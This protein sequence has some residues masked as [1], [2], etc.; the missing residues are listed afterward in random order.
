MHM[1]GMLGSDRSQLG[2]ARFDRGVVRRVLRFARPYRTML[3]AYLGVIVAVALVQLIPPLIFRQIIDEAIPRG[4][5]QG[6]RGLLHLLAGLAVLA[7]MGSAALAIVDRWLSARVGEGVIYDLR[8]AVFGHVQRMPISFFTRTQTGALTNRL[9]SDVIGAQRALTTTIGGVASNLITLVT[10][11]AAMAFLEWRLTLLS[12]VVLP[13]F[14]VPAKRV[15]R[16][17]QAITR[18]QMDL[19][20]SMNTTM[21]ERFNVSGA[22]L[23]KL[24]GRAPDEERSFAARADGVRRTGIRSALYGRTF[25][26]A[27]GLV[28][29]IGTAAVYWVGGLQVI[30]GTLSVGTLVALAAYVTRLYGPLTALSNAHVDLLTAMVSFERV[31]EVLDAPLPLVD[32]PGAVDLVDPQGRIE[33]DRVRFTYP[34]KVIVPTLELDPSVGLVPVV[35]NGN[36]TD[37]D[38]GDRD[39]GEPG[40]GDVLAEPEAGPGREVLRGVSATI[41]PGQLVALVG[42][43]GGGKTTLSMLVPRLYDV[44]DGAIRIDG[45]DVRDLTQDSLHAAVGAVTQDPHLFHDTVGNNLRYARPDATDAELVEAARAAQIH[46]VIARLPEGYDTLVGERGYRLSGGEKQRLAIARM[47][48]KDPAI[49]ILDEATS[50]LDSENEAAIQ[51]ALAEALAGRTSIVIAHRLSTITTADQILV[52]DDGRIVERG[53]HGDLIAAGGLY[54]DLYR[55]LVRED[56]QH[57]AQDQSTALGLA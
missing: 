26:I 48:L 57:V 44:S 34:D 49:V 17:L 4:I 24:F 23:V 7:A 3:L 39:G 16:R 47:L 33:F 22:L 11:L 30:D 1:G 13:L 35:G 18:T 21:T 2:D 5:D 37:G 42:P 46:D 8:V 43:S 6:D 20:A 53:V 52:V 27:L 50:Q 41:E 56:V 9:N 55:T 12:L 28:G 40:D 29:A 19:N 10:T 45:Y 15:G 32:R 25:F 31:F 51:R 36:G 14:I 38:G 54:A